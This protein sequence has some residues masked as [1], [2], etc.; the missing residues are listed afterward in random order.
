MDQLVAKRRPGLPANLRVAIVHYWYVSRR[1]GERVADALLDIFPSADFFVMFH[2][3]A[4]LSASVK[5]HRVSTSFLQRVP[6]ILRLYKNLMPLFPLALE[7]FR[8]DD[9]DVVISH[10]A[11][12]TKGVLT[13]PHTQHICYTHTP[14]RY[15]WDMYHR[16]KA[17][18]PLGAVG[19]AM[20]GLSTH[21]LRQWDHAAAS[22]VDHFVASSHNG[23]ARVRKYYRRE[24]EVIYP[25]VDV[26][27]FKVGHCRE[28]FYLIVSPLVPYKRIDLAIEACNRLQRRLVV[29][30]QGSEFSALRKMAGPTVELLGFQCDDVVHEHY[31]RCRAFLFPGEEDIG[32]TPIEAQACGCPVIAFGKGGA[33]E[34]VRGV[35]PGELFDGA[36]RTGVFFPEPTVD[37]MIEAIRSFERQEKRF[38]PTVIRQQAEQFDV[39]HFRAAMLSCVAQRLAVASLPFRASELAEVV[40][41]GN[42]T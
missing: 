24:A 31:Q 7:Q 42:A 29:I 23:A 32:L 11:G 36:S 8:L 5:S 38:S 27:S 22:R 3:P 39:A 41:L 13:R 20:Y 12:P 1:G 4:A 35:F 19:R 2:N 9:Y 37:S 34:T 18:A 17:E 15:V 21:Y 33:L 28:D 14:M 40:R 6:G 25:P 30:G 10:E 16:Y 26:S